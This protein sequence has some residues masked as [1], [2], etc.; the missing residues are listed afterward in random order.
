[1]DIRGSVSRAA[2]SADAQQMCHN[3]ERCRDYGCCRGVCATTSDRTLRTGECMCCDHH[4][5]SV[6]PAHQRYRAERGNQFGTEHISILTCEDLLAL[7]P[8]CSRSRK[9]RT[10][11]RTTRPCAPV[12]D[13]VRHFSKNG[14]APTACSW[15]L[16]LIFWGDS[17]VGCSLAIGGQ[18]LG[19][20]QRNFETQRRNK[21]RKC[22][23]VRL[24]SL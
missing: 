8:M 12:S 24:P 7:A 5:S 22:N 15:A 14:T 10:F 9:Q 11:G 20:R 17:D 3:C 4:A 1:V 21:H 19:T 23:Y 18:G 16:S 13:D 2:R 6:R